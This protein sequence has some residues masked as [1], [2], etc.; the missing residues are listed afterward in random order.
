V[1]NN[2]GNQNTSGVSTTNGN[3]AL[4]GNANSGSRNANTRP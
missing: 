3:A 4:H 1:V 2:N